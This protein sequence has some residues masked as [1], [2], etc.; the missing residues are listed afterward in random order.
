MVK[1]MVRS[2]LSRQLLSNHYPRFRPGET[3]CKST[4]AARKERKAL[5]KAS[6]SAI[7]SASHEQREIAKS[8]RQPRGSS[9]AAA[10]MDAAVVFPAQEDPIPGIDPEY[11][12]ENATFEGQSD[13]ASPELPSPELPSQTPTP[14]ILSQPSA[15]RSRTRKRAPG[16]DPI[17]TD[18]KETDAEETDA[19]KAAATRSGDGKPRKKVSLNVQ[20]VVPHKLQFKPV[21]VDSKVAVPKLNYNLD[22]VLFN[23]GVYQMMDDRTGVFNFDP[24]L[25]SFMPVDEFDFDALKGFISSSKDEK[26]R[27]V[28]IEHGKKYCGS[29]SSMTHMLSHF[30]FLLSAW[31]EP[32]FNHIT[33]SMKPESK[34]FTLFSRSPAVVN[35]IYKDGVYALDADKQYDTETVLSSLGKSMEKLFTLPKEEF[36]KYRRSR[37]HLLTDEVKNADESY[38]YTMQGD[39]MMRSQLDTYDPRL[40]GTGMF[41]LK[42]RAVI[43]IRM[44]VQDYENGRGYEIRQRFGQWNSF[45]REYHDLI[46]AAFL[47]YSLQVRMGRMDGVFVAYH[48]TQR[49]FGFQYISLEEMDQALHHTSNTRLGDEEFKCSIDILQDLMDRAAKRFPERSLRL[50]IETRE[51]GVPLTYFFV[52]PVTDDDLRQAEK[53][54]KEEIKRVKEDIKTKMK[55]AEAVT[56]S[57]QED[58]AQSSLME[59]AEQENESSNDTEAEQTTAINDH[60]WEEI[61]TKIEET[62]EL[63]SLGLRSVRKA[64]QE[65]LEPSSEKELDDLMHDI[66]AITEASPGREEVSEATE[67]EHEA[68]AEDSIGHDPDQAM[69]EPVS[70]D[71]T[72]AQRYNSETTDKEDQVDNEAIAATP[73]SA[74]DQQ[75]DELKKLIVKATEVM[76]DSEG[77]GLRAFIARM[78]A[79][80]KPADTPV[81]S[82]DGEDGGNGDSVLATATTT[83]TAE[84]STVSEQS[85]SEKGRE[86]NSASEKGRTQKPR[87]LM[88]MYVTIRNR[89]YGQ[90][91]ERPTLSNNPKAI[92]DWRVEY[93]VVELGGKEAQRIYGQIVG[94]RRAIH[95][96]TQKKGDRKDFFREVLK[97]LS[98]EGTL[99]RQQIEQKQGGKRVH[100]SW[101]QSTTLPPEVINSGVRGDI[102]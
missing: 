36:E 43:S 7:D 27:Q 93:N 51:T 34:K 9:L 89:Q 24:Y 1:G 70:D 30:H 75:P 18:A 97:R 3:R 59:S 42:T 57:H 54:T 49:I 32:S 52:E 83:T 14:D 58:E 47:K 63:E 48:N 61:M 88:G 2:Q 82:V 96:A 46:R 95:M 68:M 69:G 56:L 78:A 25:A 92:T 73:K 67:S 37:S 6:L 50:H 40:P 26:L 44:D 28:T 38:H 22:K 31:R 12:P 84:E 94:R 102:I 74:P 90:S 55:V 79:R 99:H 87:E 45:E 98:A 20:T 86:S 71:Q 91:V 100:V 101:D 29:T 53:E 23:P 80:A 16:P 19:K 11:L 60:V 81:Q 85:D 41:D 15:T 13:S 72:S 8:S 21:T 64:F 65:V 77:S 4:T 17:D 10:M 5:A 33:R 35:A 39:F 66:E 62:V 76:G